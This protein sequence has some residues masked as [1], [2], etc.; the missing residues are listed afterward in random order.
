[1]ITNLNTIPLANSRLCDTL[2]ERRKALIALANPGGFH[3]IG[4][5]Q[6]ASYGGQEGVWKALQAKGHSPSLV[7]CVCGH[8]LTQTP[9][10]KTGDVI[11]LIRKV[12]LVPSFSQ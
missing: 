8:A 2:Q 12:L 9:A 1:M 11:C 10:F 6:E 3:A 5:I 7:A 4:C